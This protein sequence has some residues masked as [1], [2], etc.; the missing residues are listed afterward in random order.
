MNHSNRPPNQRDSGF[1]FWGQMKGSDWR[2]HLVPKGQRFQRVYGQG[3]AVGTRNG[4]FLLVLLRTYWVIWWYMMTYDDIWWYIWWLYELTMSS[5][6]FYLWSCRAHVS[7]IFF[8]SKELVSKSHPL[9]DDFDGGE[10]LGREKTQFV[11]H[12]PAICWSGGCFLMCFFQRKRAW[13]EP[14][15]GGRNG[16]HHELPRLRWKEFIRCSTC[17]LH[18]SGRKKQGL[19]RAWSWLLTIIIYGY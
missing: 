13:K 14:R 17:I 1:A 10:M 19:I 9:F 15:C 7:G 11:P 5:M 8:W 2:V 6:M 18:V 3:A 12:S 4:L 16:H